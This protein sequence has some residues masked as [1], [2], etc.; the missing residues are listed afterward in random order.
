[1]EEHLE[2]SQIQIS[3]SIVANVTRKYIEKKGYRIDHSS[4]VGDRVRLPNGEKLSEAE[5]ISK[6][7]ESTNKG[8]RSGLKDALEYLVIYQEWD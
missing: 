6:H 4:D 5:I 8:T 1:M 7:N 2:R 3:N